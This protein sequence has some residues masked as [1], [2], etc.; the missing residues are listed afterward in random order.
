M[1]RVTKYIKRIP[2]P[3][4]KGYYYFYNQAQLK[5]YKE[6]GI[7]PGE[8]KKTSEKESW[9]NKFANF[10]GL[11]EK[12]EVIKKIEDD[13]KQNELSKENVSWDDWKQHV[14]DYF[15]NK[16]R[17][18][19][20]FKK[21]LDAQEKTKTS[22][23][24]EK[25]KALKEE[26]K[27]E[28]KAKKET[29]KSGL[30]LK[31]MYII[32]NIYGGTK[33]E[34][35]ENTRNE[36]N[37][38][39]GELPAD[40][41]KIST[42]GIKP[43]TLSNV[44]EREPTDNRTVDVLASSNSGNGPGR[45]VRL[46]PSQIKSTRKAILELLDSK[47]NEEM[48][49]ED[50]A[51]L[52]QYEG[53]GGLK[54]D[55][56]TIHGTLYEYYTPRS[57]VSKVWDIVKKYVGDGPQKVL[58][59][60][61]GIGRFA[62]NQPDNFD[63]TMLE[64]DPISARI[65]SIL[66]PD[67]NVQNKPFEEMF[68]KGGVPVKEYKG[69]KFTVAIGNPPYGKFSGLYKGLGEGKGH[70]RYEEYFIDRGLDA[71]EDGGVMAYVVP[72]G[73]LRGNQYS[74]IKSKI[75]KKGKLVE[76]YRLPNGTFQTTGIG[77]DIIVIRK[78]KGNIDDF[79]DDKY[80]KDNP[81]HVLGEQTTR[82]DQFGNQQQYTALKAG[83]TFDSVIDN[84]DTTNVPVVP[85]GG[86]N[87]KQQVK[88]K[89]KTNYKKKENKKVDIKQ[90]ENNFKT[91]PDVETETLESFNNKYN[92]Q[93][94][95]EELNIWKNTDFQ[96][97]IEIGNLSIAEKNL[98]EKSE[99]FC[100]DSQGDFTHKVNYA[101]GD[102]Y[103]KLEDLELLKDQIDIDRYERQKKILEDSLPEYQ[104][105]K[106]F[107]VSP[108]SDFAK[109]FE[110]N[111]DGEKENIPFIN[112][113]FQWATGRDYGKNINWQGGVTRHDIPSGISWNDIIKYIDQV[114]VTKKK[115]EDPMIKAKTIELR[116]EVTEKLFKRF[117]ETGLNP[118]EQKQLEETYNHTFNA[119]KAP[120][121]SK[122]PVF[123]DGISTKFKG[124]DLIV[125]KQQL[126]G[127]SFLANKGNGLLA[128]DVGLGK[129]MCGIMSTVNQLQTGRSKRPVVCVPKAV[130]DNW[131]AE[132]KQLF[133]D[134]EIN[135]LGNLGK[136]FVDPDLSIK[137]GTL[138][139]MTYEALQKLTFKPETIN[140]DLM[141]D[142]IDSQQFEKEGMT[143]KQKADARQSILEKLGM[144]VKSKTAVKSNDDEDI[145]E[146]DDDEEI[147]EGDSHYLENLGFDHI[148]IDEVHNFKNV[149]G[150]A[151]PTEKQNEKGKPRRVANE[152]Q[153]LSGGQS[154]RAM[155]MFAL[156]QV[157]QK[158]NNDRNV[159]ALSATPFT[160]SPL[161]IYNIL[162]LVARKKLKEL[163]IYNL[164]EFMAQFAKIKSEW[165]VKSNGNIERKNVMKEF[166][167]L[168]SLQALIREYIDKV[169]GK[170]AGIE[171]PVKNT[172]ITEIDMSP[173]QK[174][175]YAV[176]MTRFDQVD[177]RGRPMPGAVL[178]AINNMRMAS[179]SPSLINFENDS[180]YA[181]T[182]I[183][184]MVGNDDL[185]EDS[186]KLKFT[187]D[188]IAKTYAERPDLGQ[189]MYLPR[190]I[191][192][193]S[194]I[195]NN[196]VKKGV[197]KNA[198][199]VI[200]SKTK[201]D[202]K[203]KIMADFNDP[204]GTIK[205]I[206]GS[207][208]IK[209]G[210]NLNGN[211]AILYNTLLGWN[212]SE[213]TQVEG[214]IWRQGNKQGNVHIVYPQLI[215]SVDASMYQ[216]HDEKRERFSALWSFKGNELNVEDINAEELK[217]DLIKDPER[218]AKFSMDL[219]LEDIENKKREKRIFI[220]ILA[221]FQSDYKYNEQKINESNLESYK[222]DV[223]N[224]EES[225]KEAEQEL[226][227]FKKKNNKKDPDY[228]HSQEN[229]LERQIKYAKEKLSSEKKYVRDEEREIKFAEQANEGIVSKLNGMG[230]EYSKIEDRMAKE[231][232]EVEELHKKEVYIKEHKQEYIDQEKA[233]IELSKKI[234]PQLNDAVN[235]QVS[236]ILGNLKSFSSVKEAG[237]L[238]KNRFFRNSTLQKEEKLE[239]AYFVK[240][241]NSE[242]HKFEYRRVR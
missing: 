28:K 128:Y 42:G 64:L 22:D 66:F 3:S 183:P 51:L 82:S 105:T 154:A 198:I 176:E 31:L 76:A 57:V 152:F 102:I 81:E 169:D 173:L 113:F 165:A 167:N 222:Q 206:I 156:T 219:D 98:I 35:S 231:E 54:E 107:S 119:Y 93:F 39:R 88:E 212:P 184:E 90:Q 23:K 180:L 17:W 193:T 209:E 123:I 238:D 30:N 175:I 166:Q 179:L 138:S 97:K 182:D 120:D 201:A 58:E 229:Y 208:T 40:N 151:K 135:E 162:S 15:L 132:I 6:K 146:I 216:K 38:G 125:K 172:H 221:K 11:S 25:K 134:I 217:F 177:D 50:I 234:A 29:K 60:S 95:K 68:M 143:D 43:D 144:A 49:P 220:D 129:T 170:E 92:K 174:A 140:S 47:T 163:G 19:S 83:E 145:E 5:A 149:F 86:Q 186:P 52:R 12:R 164:H 53:A 155:K 122:I 116:R 115:G 4:G 195:I 32:Y 171:R 142:M 181:G 240:H 87:E 230:I 133:P 110:F 241:F 118:D 197:P 63:F 56:K 70:T 45:N 232:K 41:Q 71:L 14:A 136:Q 7:L 237:E 27:E 104:T 20:L 126:K 74:E 150:A 79:L 189:V 191:K 103:K 108:L 36:T 141:A 61:A 160:N 100:L 242:T 137:E 235:N 168:S 48:T 111:Y 161:E 1:A 239:K 127:V 224:A 218:R 10:F 205:V 131:I 159:F 227:D 121:F 207:E 33:S 44:P 91:M 89:I 124:K 37:I 214:R 215:D 8:E 204:N 112:R 59:P 24:K 85:I 158:N 80:F 101:S 225:L 2:K 99:N 148:T 185:V 114:T 194:I 72:S 192:K 203:A 18:D 213:T 196:F 211:S 233:E 65:N 69:K 84:I 187:T 117:I 178:K 236:V 26:F 106:N 190:G 94:D 34:T 109:N 199:A 153:G 75:A 9:I 226:K 62:E 202:K 78:E 210:V 200:D 157:I 139:V 73:F 67:A 16:D 55:D 130:Y 77:T 188:S 21:K 147:V 46:K 13:Y 223:V 96:G 228:D